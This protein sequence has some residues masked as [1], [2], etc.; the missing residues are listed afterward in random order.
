MSGEFTYIRK[1]IILQNN[2]TNI[3]NINPK[4]YGKIEVKGVKGTINLNIENSEEDKDYRIY[5]LRD[6]NGQVK[7]QD[8]GR[9]ITDERGKSRTSINLNL[10][11]LE[12]KGFS[13]DEIDAILIRRGINILLAGY[14]EKD[15]ETIDRFIKQLIPEEEDQQLLPPAEAKGIKDDKFPIEVKAQ[16]TI[17]QGATEKL[18]VEESFVLEEEYIDFPEPMNF[19]QIKETEE[20]KQTVKTEEEVSLEE[21]KSIIEA[22]EEVNPE[23]AK[24]A[25]GTYEESSLEETVENQTT[26]ENVPS[27]QS[28]E[29]TRRL[30]HKDQMTKYILS[31]LRFFPN[32]QPLR[33]YLHGYSW[34]RIEDG[35]MDSY[36]GFLPYYNYLMSTN[37]KYPFLDNATTCLN[38]IRKY[39]HYLFGM[40]KDGKEIK[41]YIYGVPGK[42]TIGEQPFKGITG[43]N[44]WYESNEGTGYWVLYIDPMTGKTIH[45]INPM[46]PGN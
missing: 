43:F 31:I 7:E 3:K 45:P 25:V 41:Y 39:G 38:L 18:S 6:I 20:T 14:I 22:E 23:K 2:Y 30:N 17:T 15:N 44:T 19:E 16:E 5:F 4:G 1:Y 35:G 40:Y 33:M 10:R 8:L 29:Y 21:S 24:P 42:F 36:K 34:W 26:T 9:I 28:L 32:V 37:Y 12:N 46:V 27:Y 13:I 11:D